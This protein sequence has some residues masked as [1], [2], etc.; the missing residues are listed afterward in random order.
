MRYEGR[1]LNTTEFKFFAVRSRGPGGQNVNKVN[2]AAILVW[3]YQSSRKLNA[4][5][6]S[7]VSA[8][9][10]K[11]IN[12]DGNIQIR[13]DEFRDLERNKSRCIEKLQLHLMRAF[14]KPAPRVAS[15]PTRSSIKKRLDHKRRRGEV[16]KT[17]Q[18]KDY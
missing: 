8:K 18:S 6:K 3:D 17:R 4:E 13:S 12:K 10:K 9:C 16:K 15:K 11:L 5:E 7:L 2:S 1:D 14:H